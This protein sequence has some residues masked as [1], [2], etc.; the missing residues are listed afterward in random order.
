[1]YKKALL[2]IALSIFCTQTSLADNISRDQI[3]NFFQKT[4]GNASYLPI[5]EKAFLN[6]NISWKGSIFSIQYQKNFQRTEVSMKILPGTIMYDTIVYVPGDITDKFKPKDE[7]SF[8]GSISRGI[9]M[10]G[11]Q[12]VQVK[13]GKN[14]GD[15]FGDYIFAEEGMVNVNF[16]KEKQNQSKN[17]ST[18]QDDFC[19]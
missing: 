5:W 12:E 10:L 13:I 8:S 11:I 2:L 7:V 15:Q 19:E 4:P 1:M 14:L 9:D 3:Q 17:K 6:K 18:E 16:L